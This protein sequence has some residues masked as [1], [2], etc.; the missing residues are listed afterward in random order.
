MPSHYG[1]SSMTKKLP[2]NEKKKE[3]GRNF[4]QKK[5]GTK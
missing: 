2:M 3:K 1:S 4:S 5:N